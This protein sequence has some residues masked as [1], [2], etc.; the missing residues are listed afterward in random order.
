MMLRDLGWRLKVPLAILAVIVMTEAV[1]TTLLVTRALADARRD[2]EVSAESLVSLLARSLREPLLRDDLWQAFEVVTAP[3]ADRRPDHPLQG[4]V[5]LDGDGQVFVASDPRR[6]P[7]HAAGGTLPEPL[8]AVAHRTRE[9]VAFRFALGAGRTGPELAAAGP[10]LAEDGSLLGTVVL[11]F[12]ADLYGRRRWAAVADVALYSLPGLLLLL[13]LG[14]YAGHRLAG[15]LAQ[16]ARALAQVGRDDPVQVARLLPPEGGDEVGRLSRQARLMLDGL[17]RK[18]ALER[19][20]LASERMAA[21]GR[22]AAAVAHEINNPLGG[23][24]NAIDTAQRHGVADGI[25][26]KTLGLLERGLRQ[27]RACVSAL[28]VEARLDSPLLTSQDWDDLFVLVGHEAAS[29]GVQLRW[30]VEPAARGGVPLPAH[31]VRQLVL[32][33]LLNS[34]AAAR[35][36]GAD[37]PTAELAADL[38]GDRLAIRV[39]NT[40][41][42]LT[43]ERIARLFEPFVTSEGDDGAVRHGIGLWVCWQIVQRAQGSLDA[44][45]ADGWTRVSVTLPVA[46]A[47]V[48]G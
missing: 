15:P 35:A 28:L 33:L 9:A 39:G 18:A 24:L 46:G 13:P 20:V 1:V 5:V 48:R 2:L 7:V 43:P 32:N 44:A 16:M 3:I 21:V 31:D 26:R 11:D 30:R 6:F 37:P 42:P 27:I 41:P 23:M 38:D 36:V 8:A 19:E 4:V 29:R 45:S 14:W 12:D 22:L 10:I 34:L 40:G 25:T 17:A 47:T